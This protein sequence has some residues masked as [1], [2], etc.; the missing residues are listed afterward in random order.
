MISPL[1]TP[2]HYPTYPTIL[3]QIPTNH[4]IRLSRRI[5]TR[6]RRNCRGRK[7]LMHARPR[8]IQPQPRR[9]QRRQTIQHIKR[10]NGKLLLIPPNPAGPTL[11]HALR[12]PR[13][14]IKGFFGEHSVFLD[15]VADEEDGGEGVGE[16]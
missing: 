16:L 9:R 5:L 12:L 2:P 14:R 3:T 10:I 13:A 4:E 15:V 11:I 6:K 1:F 8:R 7:R